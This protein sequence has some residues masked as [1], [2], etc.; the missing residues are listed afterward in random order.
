MSSNADRQADV[1]R[2]SAD[3][4][5]ELVS[6]EDVDGNLGPALFGDNHSSFRRA[7]EIGAGTGRVTQLLMARCDHVAATDISPSML[8]TASAKGISSLGVADAVALPFESNSADLTVA[9]WVFAHFRLWM[10]DDWR[11]NTDSAIDEMRRVLTPGGR[12]VII[13]SLGTGVSGARPPNK[14]LAEFHQFLSNEHDL[15]LGIIETDYVF[16]T[17]VRAAEV[18]GEFFGEQFAAKVLENRWTRIPEFT[19]VWSTTTG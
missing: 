7:V 2:D 19:G 11:Q 10:P 6:A 15:T 17:V 12:L 18:T 8:A 13:E 14:E 9:G 3:A 5:D 1:Y 4:Y 16:D